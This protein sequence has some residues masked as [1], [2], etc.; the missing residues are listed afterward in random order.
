MSD[1]C[2]VGRSAILKVV[3]EQIFN[4]DLWDRTPNSY[5]E[6][7]MQYELKRL[8]RHLLRHLA[9]EEEQE[10]LEAKSTMFNAKPADRLA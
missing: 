3:R 10:E 6:V 9:T 5:W 4:P 8:H 2:D 1:L 7:Q